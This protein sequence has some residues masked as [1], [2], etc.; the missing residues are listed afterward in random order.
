MESKY[1]IIG[2]CAAGTGAIEAIREVDP[3]GTIT[4]ISEELYPQYSRPMI[5]ELVSGKSDLEKMKIRDAT[6]WQKH[7]VH[8]LT[9]RTALGINV[10]EKAVQLD[11][12]EK[13]N[14]EKL[15]IATG[16]KPFV[17]KMEGQDKDGV[18]TFTTVDSAQQLITTFNR[19]ESSNHRSRPSRTHSCSQFSKIRPR[20]SYF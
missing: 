4:L 9:G 18:F 13:V 8:A 2:G 7:T 14:Y 11:N 6:F 3:L 15:L 17:P 19:Q 1:V 5:S 10:N 16:G 12:G 20:S